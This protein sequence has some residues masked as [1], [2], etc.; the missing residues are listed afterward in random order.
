MKSPSYKFNED[1]NI[2]FDIIFI[3]PTVNTSKWSDQ[4]Q[5]LGRHSILNTWHDMSHP[6]HDS[7]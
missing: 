7:P 4:K 3:T 5:V 1:H 2:P 6:Y